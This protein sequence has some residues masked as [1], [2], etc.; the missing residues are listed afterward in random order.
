MSRRSDHDRTLDACAFAVPR[1]LAAQRIVTAAMGPL[2][3]SVRT[4]QAV[5]V[6]YLDTF[7]RRLRR[8]GL[9]LEHLALSGPPVLRC[10]EFGRAALLVEAPGAA[11]PAFA[12]DVSHARLHALLSP[13]IDVRRLLVVAESRGR[14]TIARGCDR[15]DK[16][17]LVVECFT[18][19]RGP[20]R[21]TVCPLRG[22][23]R[24]AR[25]AIERLRK[26]QEIESDLDPHEPMLAASEG[27]DAAFGGLGGPGRTGLDPGE[28]SDAACK[29][30]LARLDAVLEMNA[31]GIEADLD[32]ECLHD[33]RVATRRA[34]SL[35]REMKCVFPPSTTRR[36]RSDLGWLARCT[37]T[38]RDLDVHLMELGS[39][40][41]A[42]GEEAGARSVPNVGGEGGK[43][44]AG[45]APDP[46][47][48]EQEGSAR[49]ALGCNDEGEE[50]G[51]AGAALLAHFR[52]L[53]EREFRALRRTL[54]SAR[55]RRVRSTFRKF[56]ESE[57][58]ARPRS[59]NALTPIGVLSAARILKV[60]RRI[61]TEGRAIRD[62]SPPESL[63][64]LR[65]SCKRLRYL[66]EFFRDLHPAKPVER[67]IAR[68]KRLQDNLGTYQDVQVQRAVLLEFRDH[69]RAF[70]DA[71][72]L[73]AVDRRC[74]ALAGREGKARAKF[75]AL[76]ARYDVK[77]SHK[78]F[79]RALGGRRR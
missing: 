3:V 47:G 75:P 28:R 70:L 30:L 72:G 59:E 48:V 68:L 1:H 31:P 78:Q 14:L 62:D 34:R 4:G 27:P 23:E 61:L 32:P 21:L 43:G 41:R 60:Y 12:R 42:G 58:P 57:P 8:A 54:R 51:C 35:L 71:A 79:A 19:P 5:H 25:R 11:L 40:A 22:Y 9:V 15:E 2:T 24:F 13:L 50:G 20:T 52:S 36:L 76:F 55:Y 26:A 33:F 63:H 18:G 39:T 37:G 73:A 67:T 10:R 6:R 29:R 38:V 46:G 69:A 49:A 16:T 64:E 74:A 65:K 44:I 56:L 45:S 17:M 77:R 53:R 7:D 66:L